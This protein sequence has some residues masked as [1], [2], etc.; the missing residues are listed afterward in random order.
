[1]KLAALFFQSAGLPAPETEYKFH[2]ERKWR[3]DYAYPTHKVALEVEG[4]IWMGGRH[5]RGAG[6][7][8]DMEKYNAAASSG[9]LVIRVE[10]ANLLTMNTAQL[11]RGALNSQ[12]SKVI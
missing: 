5:S 1:M 4:G 11:L 12:Q 7:R 9:W 8:N 10:P 3:F 2:D 6:M